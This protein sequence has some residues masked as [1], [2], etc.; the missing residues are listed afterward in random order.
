[1]AVRVEWIEVSVSRRRYFVGHRLPRPTSLLGN[2]MAG[3]T[4]ASRLYN[5][6]GEMQ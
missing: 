5:S 4:P 1:M 3:S 6:K 2:P